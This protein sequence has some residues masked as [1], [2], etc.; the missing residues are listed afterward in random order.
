MELLGM[1]KAKFAKTNQ[2][3]LWLWGNSD[4][5]RKEL[6]REWKGTIRI[7]EKGNKDLCH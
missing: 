5:N 3:S 6:Y 7:I 1:V 2:R 4:N